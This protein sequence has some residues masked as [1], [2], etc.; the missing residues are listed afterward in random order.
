MH[1][2]QI[3]IFPFL[4]FFRNLDGKFGWLKRICYVI[5]LSH[6]IDAVNKFKFV[7][8]LFISQYIITYTFNQVKQEIVDQ[9]STRIPPPHRRGWQWAMG[10]LQLNI[11]QN[12]KFAVDIQSQTKVRV[13]KPKNPIWP[14][15]GHFESDRQTDGRTDK[16]NPVYPPPSNFVGRGYKDS[17]TDIQ[18]LHVEGGLHWPAHAL[19]KVP[20]KMHH[21]SYL[22]AYC[23]PPK[24]SGKHLLDDVLSKREASIVNLMWGV[25]WRHIV[26]LN[27]AV[28]LEPCNDAHVVQASNWQNNLACFGRKER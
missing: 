24:C 21:P 18:S 15:G 28:P 23:N 25:Y 16:V 3:I 13:W 10:G 2:Q 20:V 1:V 17:I 6:H 11:V 26:V 19:G 22:Y 27:G 14:P 5:N 12:H 4:F 7:I 9:W 8:Q